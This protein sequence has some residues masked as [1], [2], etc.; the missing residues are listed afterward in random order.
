[1][2]NEIRDV[3]T[4]EQAA[5]YLQV[6]RKTIYRYIHQG[7]LVASRLGQ[8][9]RIPKR[10]LDFLLWTTLSRQLISLRNYAEHEI[11]EFLAVDK[12]DD[13][14]N[15]VIQQFVSASSQR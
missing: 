15:R 9:Y 12:L 3:F 2:A 5:Q 13:D 14:T 10:S 8:G 4:T 6:S 11:A 7:K 1:M